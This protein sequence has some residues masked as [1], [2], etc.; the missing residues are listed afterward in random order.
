MVQGRSLMQLT[1]YEHACFTVEQEGQ[2]LVA[3]P[4]EWTTDFVAPEHVVGIVIT[5]EHGDHFS[6]SQIAAIVNKNP[7]AV[8]VAH[9][10]ITNTIKTVRTKAVAVDDKVTVV[11]FQLEFFGGEH[12]VIYSD[13]PP[14]PNL[15]A[16]INGSLYYPGDSFA[17]PNRPVDI[18]ALPV[19]APWL[20]IRESLDFFNA[21]KA[22]FTFPTHDAILSDLG[23]ATVDRLLAAAAEKAGTEYRRIDETTITV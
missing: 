12:A 2:V 23:K 11:P 17:V 18:L 1:K 6:Q 9:Q 15:G 5:H 10:S 13:G 20:K 16:L 19:S 7:D 21:I 22:R 8:I 3:D 4:G 14:T